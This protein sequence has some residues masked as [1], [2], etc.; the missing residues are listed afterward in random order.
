M[1]VEVLS[2]G[3]AVLPATFCQVRVS[4][5]PNKKF[6]LALQLKNGM[7]IPPLEVLQPHTVRSGVPPI[8]VKE[9]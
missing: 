4:A 3:M 8:L 1:L 5:N 6:K 2:E 7:A 9:F